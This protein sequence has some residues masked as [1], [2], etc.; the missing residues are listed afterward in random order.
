MAASDSEP[1][2]ET[3]KFSVTNSQVLL[4]IYLNSVF[5]LLTLGNLI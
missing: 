4:I 5:I 1:G 3:F 2:P